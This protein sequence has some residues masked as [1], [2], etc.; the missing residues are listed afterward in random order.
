MLRQGKY[1]RFFQAVIGACVLTAA[2]PCTH[3]ALIPVYNVSVDTASLAADVN[4]QP[5]EVLLQ[6]NGGGATANTH[7]PEQLRI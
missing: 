4:D 7:H 5:F 2:A 6:L 3:A 1:A